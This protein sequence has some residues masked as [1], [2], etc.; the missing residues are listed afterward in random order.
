MNKSGV[1]F[2]LLKLVD[3]FSLDLSKKSLDGAR[4]VSIHLQ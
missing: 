4:M 1:N 3:I 2:G